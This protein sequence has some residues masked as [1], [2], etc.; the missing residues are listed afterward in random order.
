[1]LLAFC[2]TLSLLAAG[3]QAEAVFML[4]LDAA[5][6][7]E[8]AQGATPDQA[9]LDVLTVPQ[10]SQLLET[11]LTEL[12]PL[13]A[14]SQLNLNRWIILRVPGAAGSV[15]SLQA[16]RKVLAKSPV[17]SAIEIDYE[18]SGHVAAEKT[19]PP[20]EEPLPAGDVRP[21]D[22]LFPLQYYHRRIQTPHAW[23]LTTGSPH[24]TVAVLDTG[25]NMEIDDL[26][27]R[28]LPG[29]DF[30]NNTSE[31]CDEG[32]HGTSITALIAATG[33]NGVGIAGVDWNCRI[34]PIVMTSGGAG[35]WAQAIEFAIARGAHVINISGKLE[36]PEPSAMLESLLEQAKSAGIV[37]VASAG[38]QN[39]A[40]LSW[41]ASSPHVIAVGA[42]DG[43][44]G[45]WRN[46][47]N[48]NG[49]NYGPGLD[50]V[51]PGAEIVSLSAMGA[52]SG[53]EGTSAAAALVSGACALM[54]GINPSLTPDQVQEIL[55]ETAFKMAGEKDEFGAGLLNV[56][57]AVEAAANAG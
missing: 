41:P 40:Q 13:P 33:D 8:I 30:I 5:K 4:K 28:G 25:S 54:L 53:G 46:P 50:I 35:V 3:P 47:M 31:V 56:G 7:A 52:R 19:T 18:A 32:G 20:G 24:I 36:Q 9:I 43:F 22:P 17:V 57:A 38:N 51:A 49:S 15:E 14:D 37:I 29:Y 55:Q 12:Q 34:L 42:M 44:G 23:R 45:R 16:L 1:M 27:G 26:A 48:G 21:N 39:A 2:I 11:P 6:V 10:G